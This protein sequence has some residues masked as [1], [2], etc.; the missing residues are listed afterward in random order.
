[1]KL[2]NINY[3][4]SNECSLGLRI[5]TDR[6]QLI[7]RALERPVTKR[8]SRFDRPVTKAGRPFGPHRA[9]RGE[10]LTRGRNDTH[11]SQSNI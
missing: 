3:A 10:R 9:K 2:L 1:M 7:G 4:I 11:Q 5:L 6:R 8:E